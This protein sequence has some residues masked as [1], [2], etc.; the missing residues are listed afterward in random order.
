MILANKLKI[1]DF[2]KAIKM[3]K[4]NSADY[5]DLYDELDDGLP[6]LI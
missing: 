1:V 4:S 2:K 6:Q 5:F 3:L